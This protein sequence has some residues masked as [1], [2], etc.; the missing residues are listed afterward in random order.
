MSE[1]LTK[2]TRIRFGISKKLLLSVVL[3]TVLICAIST[4]SGYFQYQNT[5]R[6]LYNDN[7]YVTANIILDHIDHDKIAHYAQTWTE[8]EDY[9]EMAE[10]LKSVEKASGAAYIYIVTFSEDHT[11]RY[12]YDSSGLPIGDTDPVSSYFDEAWATYTKGTRTNSYMV[13]HSKKYGYLTSSMLPVKDS[14]GKVVAVL[15]VDVW[16]EMIMT[17]LHGYIVKMVLISLGILLIFSVL[18]WA[19]MRKKFIS[20]LMRIR[21]NVTEFAKNETETTISLGDIKT[22]DEIQELADSIC[23]MEN[24]IIKYISNIQAITAE[25]ERIGAELNVATQI[26]ADMLPRIFPPFPDRTEFDIYATMTPA[27]EVGGDFYDFFLIDENHLGMVMADV[28]GKGV[29]AALFMVIAKTLIKNRA[30]MGGGPSEILQYVNEQLCQGNEA[31]LFVTVWFAILDITTGKGMAANA[32]HEHPVIRRANGEYELVQYRHSP[33][34]AIMDSIRFKE[35]E[36]EMHPGDSLF[37]YTDG[38][39]EATNAKNE[40]YGTERMLEALNNEPDAEPQELL[41]NVQNGIN[42]F[43]GNAPQFDDITMMCLAYKGREE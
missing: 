10:Y 7:G 4:I 41:Q 37:V 14:Q 31:E 39:T 23:L 30:Q 5:I 32:G 43:V 20:P 9:A 35:H 42:Q 36:F 25:K 3:L 24:D 22:K 12:I 2:P 34:I 21:G 19:F 29:P 26:Q 40:L 8:D 38:V 18:Y 16:M 17:T 13:R 15:L 6:K 1:N 33:A 11:M 28:S 27:K